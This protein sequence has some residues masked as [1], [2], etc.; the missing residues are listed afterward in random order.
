MYEGTIPAGTG[1]LILIVVGNPV[2][3]NFGLLAIEIVR[4]AEVVLV[5]V[6]IRYWLEAS[7]DREPSLL[8]GLCVPGVA[9]VQ[10]RHFEPFEE[11]VQ[12]VPLFRLGRL[13]LFLMIQGSEASKCGAS[14]PISG[15][16]WY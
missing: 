13:A 6:G 1:Y 7:V 11:R 16:L 12:W 15:V 2:E 3:R 14:R 5:Y 4:S 10:T 9:V 8:A